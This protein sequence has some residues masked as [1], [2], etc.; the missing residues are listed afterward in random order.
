MVVYTLEQRWEMLRYFFENHDNVTECVRKLSTDFE[1]TEIPSASYVRYLVK[2]ERSWHPH[3]DNQ[4]GKIQKQ[5]KHTR[6]LL[7]LQKV[8]LKHHQQQFTVVLSNW[9]IRSH[10]GDEFCIKIELAIFAFNRTTLRETQPKPHAVLWALSLKIALS[11][12]EL[13]S[14]GVWSW[15]LTP[16][17]Y[18]LW[19]AIED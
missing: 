9:R 6:I 17:D 11:A 5:C 13:I 12:V 4:N 2:S 1:R 19:R 10:H 18:C 7:L 8:C 14:F 15:D 16:L 3:P